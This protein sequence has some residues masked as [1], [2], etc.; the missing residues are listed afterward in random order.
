MT[1][2]TNLFW[3]APLL[4]LGAFALLAG[5]LSPYGRRAARL[6]VAAA[7]GSLVI[8][9]LGLFA[10]AQGARAVVGVPWMEIGGY[11]LGLALWLDPLGILVATLVTV[12]GLI[13]FVYAVSYIVNDPRVGCFFAEL[14]LFLGAM[15]TLV[16]AADLLTLFIA[17]E[18]V[19]ICSYLL[20][21]FWFEKPG[22]PYAA[23]NAF[24]TTRIGDLPM[25]VGI[26]FLVG[27]VGSSRIDA[28]LAA[29]STG[30]LSPG[31]LLAVALLLLTGAAGKS[32]QVP[33]QGWLPDAMLGPTPVSALIHSATMVAAGVFLI[34][35]LYPLFQAAGPALGV[36]AWVGVITALLGAA[37]ALVET[38]LKRTL[39]Y[40]TMSQ[41]GLMFVG[42]G[43]GSLLAG[44]LL[45]I[46]QALYKST[47]FLAAGAVEH[48]VGGTAF[49][50][51]GG[52]TKQMP[53][54]FIAFT[55]AAAALAGLPVTLAL[56][57]KDP[58]LAAS[59]QA[60][61]ALCALALLASLLTAL[62]SA[63]ALALVFLGP[64]SKSA[65]W[66]HVAQPGLTIPTLTLG[67]LVIV[68]SLVNA[69][70]L[71]R[72][73]GH[74]L[75][76]EAPEARMVSALGLAVAA[77]GVGLGLW[78]RTFWS[79]RVI[80]PP[81]TRV[82]DLFAA[83]FGLK[84][85]YHTF[86][87]LGLR[88]MEAA[89]DVDRWTFDPMGTRFTGLAMEAVQRASGFDR[90][91]FDAF[92]VKAAAATLAAVRA[93][94][95]FDLRGIEAAVDTFGQTLLAVSQRVRII[96][97]GHVGNYLLAIFIWGL[98]LIALA[99]LAMALP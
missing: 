80:W 59:W 66:A 3:L 69:P 6:A 20:I 65:R 54:T 72:P 71:G 31:L 78:A 45:L 77:V 43:S 37:A 5:G 57:T 17:W 83:E 36:M 4:P 1:I 61:A 34:A 9:V 39:A 14:S 10:S 28:A 24:L 85:L 94:L 63:R 40:S 42:L 75:G 90:M 53:Y 19:G 81:F 47:L 22:V 35:R 91:I 84:A 51:M 56:P 48:A 2:G 97:T 52:L 87:R 93:G 8:S 23:T 25:L 64:P 26:L 16:L 88:A 46:A 55:I 30:G 33:L 44:V 74:L 13:V 96:Q 86:T 92:A 89:S 18:L 49:E 99:A 62:Y 50:R 70:L 79:E 29:A 73:L 76:A 41:L 7:A 67:G 82:A 60:S 38:D 98:G 68:G 15:L 32:A 21:G 58:T 11:R 95:R 12:V 27:A